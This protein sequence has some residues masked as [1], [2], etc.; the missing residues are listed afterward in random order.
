MILQWHINVNDYKFKFFSPANL[1]NCLQSYFQE[2]A[3][4]F[5]HHQPN[6]LPI[7]HKHLRIP[8]HDRPNLVRPHW[9]PVPAPMQSAQI[10]LLGQRLG[11]H[12][13][14]LRGEQ[15]HYCFLNSHTVFG[16]YAANLQNKSANFCHSSFFFLP[17]FFPEYA[18]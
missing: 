6:Q 4:G 14:A 13:A 2:I 5:L 12:S 11:G 18:T 16:I 15:P 9:S 3:G 7:P 1:E 17:N 10:N 8:E